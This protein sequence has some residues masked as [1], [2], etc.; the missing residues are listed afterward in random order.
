MTRRSLVSF[1][2]L[3]FFSSLLYASD[4]SSL[5]ESNRLVVNVGGYTFPPF[6]VVPDDPFDKPHG[7][8]M[9]IIDVLN[10]HQTKYNFQF[11]A[12]TPKGRYRSFKRNSFDVIFFESKKWGW[13]EYPVDQSE[14]FLSGG[15]VYIAYKK[16]G[17]DQSFFDNLKNK[18][19]MAILGYHYG[20][21]NFNSDEIYLRENFDI[22]LTSSHENS[23]RGLF[24]R[25][26]IADVAVVTKSYLDQY[27][28]RYPKYRDK[29]LISDRVDQVYEHTVLVRQGHELTVDEINRYLKE[30]SDNGSLQKI[31]SKYGVS[32]R[33]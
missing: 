26:G 22:Y 18:K 1:F 9:D 31:W 29:L 17:R 6:L 28:S 7:M 20:F 32:A 25:N 4:N 27:L 21:A 30:L 24:S 15:E 16:E 13:Q 2:T 10:A 14:S 12:T 23:I 19:M 11:I 8:A 33:P 3:L 5:N